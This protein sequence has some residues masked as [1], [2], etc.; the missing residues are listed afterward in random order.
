MKK[1]YIILVTL[2]YLFPGCSTSSTTTEEKE[3]NK[4]NYTI[5]K[6]AAGLKTNTL[7]FYLPPNTKLDTIQISDRNKTVVINFSKEFS[8]IPLRADNV[9]KFYDDIK[10]YFGGAYDGYDFTL[11]SMNIEISELIPNFYR[12]KSDYD[13]KRISKNNKKGNVVNNVSKPY[14][15]ELGLNDRNIVLWHSHGWYYNN[16]LKRWEWQ[17][18]RLFQAVED[19]IPMSFTLPY[20]IPMLENAGANV[21]VPRER[22]TQ[23]NEVVVDNDKNDAS[24]TERGTWTLGKTSGFKL[25]SSIITVQNPFKLGTYR[26]TNTSSNETATITYKPQIPEDGYY[27]VYISYAIESNSASD[28]EYTVNHS[29]GKT[30]FKVDQSKGGST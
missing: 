4:P 22:D 6:F 19:R 3:P 15:P 14:K 12:S 10:Q 23:I 18:P 7:P 24:Y 20:L 2:F 16:E 17:R 26:Q 25:T 5:N 9:K 13:E 29:G 21:F 27:A 11:R 28:V 8:Y 1:T 30:I